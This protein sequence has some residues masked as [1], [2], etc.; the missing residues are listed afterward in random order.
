MSLEDEITDVVAK[1]MMG[2]GMDAGSLAEKAG[3]GVAGIEGILRGDFD[4]DSLRKIAPALGLDADALV[5]LPDYFPEK[6]EIPGVRRI[7]LPYRQWTVN[8]WM[9]EAG[10]V[11][12]L[13]DTGFGDDDVIRELGS[14]SP[15][16][17]LITHS[18]EDHVGGI[19]GL[20]SSG[21]RVIYETEAL[22]ESTF[23]FG[24]ISVR[25]VDLS[26]HKTPTAG[27]FIE[28]LGQRILVAGDA[29]FAG[30]IGRCRSTDAYGTA[31]I[32]LRL[33]LGEA[34]SDCVILPGHGPATTVTEELA[35]NPFHLEFG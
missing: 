22:A 14:A 8:A 31:F 13:F 19:G 18:H 32:N 33:V 27:Y 25:V 17:V 34:G 21:V 15:N 20:E 7:E 9:V 6:Q 1:A 10:G 30:S 24:A 23:D 2:L 28:G 5:D 4:Q 26:G 11:K 3:I 29:I 16:V 35:S 12:M